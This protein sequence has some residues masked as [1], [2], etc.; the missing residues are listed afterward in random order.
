MIKP[1]QYTTVTETDFPE[2]RRLSGPDRGIVDN[3]GFHVKDKGRGI[4]EMKPF[5]RPRAV[6]MR[7]GR[8]VRLVAAATL[9][10]TCAAAVH[11]AGSSAFSPPPPSAMPGG[12]Y[13]ALVREGYR[14]FEQTPR[15]AGE[16]T[17]NALSCEN[18]HLDGGRR[19]NA[20]PLWAAFGMYPRYQAQ[21]GQVISYQQ[22]LQQC[23]QFSENGYPP[24]LDS[25]VMRAL[26][27]YSHWLATGAPI[28]VQMPGRGLE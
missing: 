10:W 3:A 21:S 6:P 25:Q 16:Y 19:S 20:I 24:P 8:R 26:T 1:A 12:Q 13:G 15:Y 14:I 17:G 18:C 28:G 11:A 5:V 9:M 23:F 4:P 22:R 2:A 7:A 27:A